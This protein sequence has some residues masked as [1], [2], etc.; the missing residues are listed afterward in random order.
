MSELIDSILDTDKLKV[1]LTKINNLIDYVNKLK[2]KTSGYF[3]YN[4]SDGLSVAVQTD[5]G[6]SS[7]T[8]GLSVK[9]ASNGGI[10]CDS[11]GLSVKAASQA[12]PEDTDVITYSWLK[13]YFPDFFNTQ[14]ATNS[15]L[16][17]T[18]DTAGS[19]K[20]DV[21]IVSTDTENLLG[22]GSDYGAYMNGDLNEGPDS[23]QYKQKNG[24]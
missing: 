13:T 6:L 18:G 8:S 22:H 12:T 2:L 9:T 19:K 4:D 3:S 20:I 7:T 17:V 5:G 10:K 16:K 24:E 21:T 15:A 1:W 23:E 11:D 14:I